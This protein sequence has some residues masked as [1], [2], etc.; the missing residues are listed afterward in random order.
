VVGELAHG[1]VNHPHINGND[2]VAG[3]L[4]E[5]LLAAAVDLGALFKPP[6]DASSVLMPARGRGI[7]AAS[8]RDPMA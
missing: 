4:V 3:F 5:S 2:R 6:G 8:S 1:D 7:A